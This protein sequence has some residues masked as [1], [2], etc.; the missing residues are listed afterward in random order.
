MIGPAVNLSARIESLCRDLERSLLISAEFAP[1]S[2]VAADPV[3]EFVLK[4]VGAKQHVFAPQAWDVRAL[5]ASQS[6]SSSSN[7]LASLRSS[8]SK[9]SVNQPSLDK[10][11][12]SKRPNARPL[13]SRLD[14][15]ERAS[16]SVSHFAVT[17]PISAINTGGQRRRKCLVRG[18]GLW[19]TGRSP[20]P[21]PG[22]SA[23]FRTGFARPRNK[24]TSRPSSSFSELKMPRRQTA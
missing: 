5:E 9:P 8:V 3:G 7:A 19:T 20:K 23:P 18:G 4:G 14:R 24:P 22:V 15:A 13:Q 11:R 1:I 12:W 16:S 21:Q 17:H 6:R 2:G 10:A